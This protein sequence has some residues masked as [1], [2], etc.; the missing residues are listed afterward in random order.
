M[1]LQ[2]TDDGVEVMV[3]TEVTLVGAA[4][5]FGD[6][7]RVRELWQNLLDELAGRLDDRLGAAATAASRR[8]GGDAIVRQALETVMSRLTGLFHRSHGELAEKRESTLVGGQR[9]QGGSESGFI[10]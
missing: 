6:G 10:R 8:V 5:H 9:L 7:D 2:P 3:R 4:A 1:E